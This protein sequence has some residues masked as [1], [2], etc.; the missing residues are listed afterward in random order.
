MSATCCPCR[1]RKRISTS[2]APVPGLARFIPGRREDGEVKAWYNRHSRSDFDEEEAE[3]LDGM[4]SM[5]EEMLGV[6]LGDDIDL[7]SPDEVVR[8]IQQQFEA[9][10]EAGQADLD[11]ASDPKQLK[12]WL[13]TV[14]LRQQRAP[15][16]DFF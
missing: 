13:K 14:S 3:Q 8:R 4:K 6:E 9:Q 7:S 11:M 15:D 1:T 2:S 5:L 12:A 10:G 16:F